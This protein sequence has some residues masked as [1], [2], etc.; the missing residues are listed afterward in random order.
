MAKPAEPSRAARALGPIVLLLAGVSAR[1][2]PADYGKVETFEPGKKY[3]CVPSADHQGWDCVE[4]GK[5]PRVTE[6]SPA[7][8]PASNASPRSSGTL[9]S[10]LTN[11]AAVGSPSPTPSLP[12]SPS[13]PPSAASSA[14]QATAAHTTPAATGEVPTHAT[15]PRPSEARAVSSA[16]LDLPSEQFV[17]ELGHADRAE[18][19]AT[20]RA[21]FAPTRGELYELH[22]RGA[23]GDRWLLLWGPFPDL[24]SARDA[25]ADLVAGGAIRPGWPRRIAPLQ[26]EL[27]HA[28]E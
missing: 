27:R 17:I 18:E 13:Q 22:L 7:K 11:A 14:P 1:A 25:R 28:Q 10:Y 15:L 5:A 12:T 26:A 9:P 24:E 3:T 6:S 19:L 23:E 16:F 2:E 4:S 8:A 21:G 20:V